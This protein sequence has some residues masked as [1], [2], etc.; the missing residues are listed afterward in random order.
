LSWEF[1]A[2]E[3]RDGIILITCQVLW[4]GIEFV[5]AYLIVLLGWALIV[6]IREGGW[7][8]RHA[9]PGIPLIAIAVVM[10]LMY[11]AYRSFLL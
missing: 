2:I 4:P 7:L 6:R 3:A 10:L 5:D 8:K 11:T 9:M 1:H